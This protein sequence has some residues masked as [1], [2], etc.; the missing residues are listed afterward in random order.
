M[1]PAFF[2]A[3]SP[4]VF[5][6][7]PQMQSL[8]A[9]GM[10]V[11]IAA[12]VIGTAAAVVSIYA[13][14]RRKPTHDEVFATKRELAAAEARLEMRYKLSLDEIGSQIRALFSK[15]DKQ[16]NTFQEHAQ[17]MERALGRIEGQLKQANQS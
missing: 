7:P 10:W 5:A 8:L 12:G 11:L 17:E 9:V 6:L 2:L 14:L 15:L 1:L 13:N 3:V 16:G 4:D